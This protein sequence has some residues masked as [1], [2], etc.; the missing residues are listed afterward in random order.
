ML[1]NRML[2]GKQRKGICQEESPESIQAKKG[3]YYSRPFLSLR[4]SHFNGKKI[5][6][7]GNGVSIS[8]CLLNVSVPPEEND[9]KIEGKIK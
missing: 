8:G 6:D 4:D 2:R 9:A 7:I 1:T 3:C 5:V